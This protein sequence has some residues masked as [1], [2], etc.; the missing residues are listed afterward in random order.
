MSVKMREKLPI[1][2][3]RSVPIR[4]LSNSSGEGRRSLKREATQDTLTKILFDDIDN[5]TFTAIDRR[6]ALSKNRARRLGVRSISLEK[7]IR[8]QARCD[9]KLEPWT[10]VI[11]MMLSLRDHHT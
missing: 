5:K 4:Q 10:L 6:S 7:L 1:R 8:F 11:R 2:K 3:V 9:S